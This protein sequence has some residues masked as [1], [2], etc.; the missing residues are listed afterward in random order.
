MTCDRRQVIFNILNLKMFNILKKFGACMTFR[1]T[2][3]EQTTKS[4]SGHSSDSTS[5]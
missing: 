1:A 2:T 4:P 5:K 3:P